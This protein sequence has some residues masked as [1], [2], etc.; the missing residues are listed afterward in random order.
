MNSVCI[1]D[2][3]FGYPG[4]KNYI[5]KSFSLINDKSGTIGLLG[6][7]GCGKSTLVKLLAGI[8]KPSKGIISLNGRSI[9]E[10]R[11]ESSI[12]YI[13][14]NIRLFLIGPTPRMDL[15]RIINDQNQV[16][17][18]FT[19]YQL[20]P[21][22]DKKIYHLSEGQRRLIA[23]MIAFHAPS[24]L[25]LLDEPTIG[26]DSKGRNLLFRLLDNAKKSGKIVVIATNDS[27]VFPR[28]DQLVV[29]QD[30]K[31]H[32]EGSP[33]KVLFDLEDNTD[34]IPNQIPRLINSLERVLGR[35]LPH[36]I[37]SEDMNRELK[38][39]RFSV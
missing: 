36:C 18:I 2:L 21:L 12:I 28:M 38:E 20:D 1:E 6:T 9:K 13:P 24:S 15:N 17:E 25:L 37:T 27:R 16:N 23:I 31:V 29:I 11:K 7:N 19:K 3:F 10:N 35:K 4:T 30:G 22:A 14:E 8:L 34:L 26:F 32:Q 5:L 33:Q 39:R